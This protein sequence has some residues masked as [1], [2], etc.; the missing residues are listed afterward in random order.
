MLLGCAVEGKDHM[1][2]FVRKRSD[3][4]S[5]SCIV[6][7]W[8]YPLCAC[9]DAYHKEAEEWSTLCSYNAMKYLASPLCC[10]AQHCHMHST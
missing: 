1:K 6:A 5:D 10:V 9:K 7:V 3:R 4:Q 2:G 8:V